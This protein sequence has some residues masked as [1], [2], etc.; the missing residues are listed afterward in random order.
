MIFHPVAVRLKLSANARN[1]IEL[2]ASLLMTGRTVWALRM[3]AEPRPASKANN[4]SL[5]KASCTLLVP[6]SALAAVHT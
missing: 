5:R 2:R 3:A 6:C 1:V 4:A